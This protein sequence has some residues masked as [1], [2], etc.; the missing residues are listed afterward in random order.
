MAKKA[1][2]NSRPS[3]PT[4]LSR[5]IAQARGDRSQRAWAAELGVS[6]QNVNRYEGRGT[7]PHYF[8][9]VTLA[10]KERINLNWLLLGEGR[11]KRAK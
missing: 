7:V 10:R 1:R 4:A 2:K 9:F 6:Q 5:R 11:M 3:T 8:F